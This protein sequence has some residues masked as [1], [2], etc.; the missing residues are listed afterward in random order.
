MKRDMTRFLS[1]TVFFVLPV[2]IGF[3]VLFRLGFFPIATNSTF[4]DN[5]ILLLQKHPLKSVRLLAIGS[6]I[7][8]YSLNSRMIV[9]QFDLPYYNFSSWSMQIGDMRTVLAPLVNDYRPAYVL[10]LSSMGDFSSDDNPTYANYTRT[11]Y[12][13]RAHFPE[14][15]YFSDYH[16][17]HQLF[18]RKFTASHLGIDAWGAGTE[19]SGRRPGVENE[20]HPG[21]SITWDNYIFFHKSEMQLQYRNLDSLGADLQRAGVVLVFAQA[22]MRPSFLSADSLRWL[23][24]RH[25]ETCRSI[26][27]RHGG[28]YFN[29]YDTTV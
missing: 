22:P 27:E 14:F 11:P 18:L 2:F 25:F 21:D 28:V 24:E 10:I 5:K 15:F 17:I 20:N 4:F 23:R 29:L 7:A 1:K 6:S 26:V 16:S 12:F 9:R 8:L 13:I 3:E 19:F